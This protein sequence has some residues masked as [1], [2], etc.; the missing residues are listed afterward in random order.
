M[1]ATLNDYATG[2]GLCSLKLCA[3]YRLPSDTPQSKEPKEQSTIVTHGD[4]ATGE[5]KAP[6]KGYSCKKKLDLNPFSW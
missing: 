6:F 3:R 2:E 4:Y 1:I 5:G